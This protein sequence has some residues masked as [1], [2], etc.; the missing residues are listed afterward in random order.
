MSDRGEKRAE[1]RSYHARYEAAN[2]RE[3]NVNKREAPTHT[4]RDTDTDR[5]TQDSNSVPALR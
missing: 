3:T 2:K 5:Q 1:E 4:H